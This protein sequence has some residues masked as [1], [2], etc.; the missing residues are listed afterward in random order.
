MPDEETAQSIIDVRGLRKSYGTGAQA[1]IAV[2]DLDLAVCR[3]EFVSLMGPSGSG[4]STLLNLIAGLDVPDGGRV[5]VDGEDLS[6]LKDHQ[7]ADMRLRKIGFV[8]Q[9][10]NLVPALTVYE[11]VAWPLEFARCSRAEVRR[12]VAEAL[13]KVGVAGR[14]E[15]FPAEM[16]GGEQQRI[17]IARAIATGPILL[18]ADEPTGNLDSATGRMILDLLRTLNT[19]DGMTVVMVTHNVFAA[20]YGDR[21]LEMRDGRIVR[22]VRM[23]P[24]QDDA[25]TDDVGKP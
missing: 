15:R 24:R 19:T 23:P 2:N 22:D 7:L 16:S 9:A 13:A 12:R 5:L 4:K 21:T 14:E 1:T 20:T 18:L 11:N 8:F 3:G 25:P 17:A 10:F 6:R